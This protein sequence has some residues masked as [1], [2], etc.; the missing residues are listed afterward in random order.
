[1]EMEATGI[2]RGDNIDEME[3]GTILY[4]LVQGMNESGLRII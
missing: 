3:F 1:M 4:G 2:H